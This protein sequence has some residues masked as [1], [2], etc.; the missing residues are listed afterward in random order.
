LEFRFNSSFMS[1]PN[2]HV[3]LRVYELEQAPC[4]DQLGASYF[5][6]NV[7]YNTHRRNKFDAQSMALEG[8][9]TAVYG[10]MAGIGKVQKELPITSKWKRATELIHQRPLTPE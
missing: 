1:A 2:I 8:P 6:M 4:I 10:K 9:P 5:A 3:G 7:D